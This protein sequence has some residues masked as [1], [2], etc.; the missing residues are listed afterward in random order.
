MV[1]NSPLFDN[2]K[3]ERVY[4]FA[5][6]CSA[7]VSKNGKHLNLQAVRVL[8]DGKEE[9]ITIPIK[10]RKNDDP[11]KDDVK[12]ITARVGA[13]KTAFIFIAELYEPKR[14]GKTAPKSQ[15]EYHAEGDDCP[16]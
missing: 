5:N 11:L 4:S 16:F 7:Y 15:A 8:D 13:D 9:I 2:E 12:N 3:R 14:T 6:V 1:G 10:I